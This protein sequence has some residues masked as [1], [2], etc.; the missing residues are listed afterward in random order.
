MA[1]PDQVIDI[2]I[3]IFRSDVR[4][5]LTASEDS[6]PVVRQTLRS[7]GETIEADEEALEDAELAVTEA[8][9]NAVEHAYPDADERGPV[10]I[11]FLP[12]DEEML[13]SVRD[14][15]RGMD[16]S[17]GSGGKDAPG[18]GLPM[19]EGIARRVDIRA[20]DGTEI[21]MTFALGTANAS[22]TT[23]DGAAPGLLPAERIL[24]RVVAVVAAQVDMSVER[25]MEALLVVE[26]VAR[27]GLRYLV[28]EHVKIR[29]TRG[30][31]A[32]DL[33][34]GPLEESGAL[35]VVKDTDVPVVGSVVQRLS[36]DVRVETTE[37]GGINCEYLLLR[38]ATR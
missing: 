26:L 3:G 16:G 10:R 19:I 17:A 35:R 4:L 11:S 38:I 13:V 6:L 32:F 8:L 12:I 20:A 34:L 5:E 24:R 23:V 31:G 1:G 25:V 18:Y 14:F 36:E 29:V 9:A 27:H 30:E 21:E 22:A 7:I 15:G 2:E 28:G 37:A 33:R